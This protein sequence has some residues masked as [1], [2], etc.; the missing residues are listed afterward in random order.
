[1]GPL[2]MVGGALSPNNAAV[3]AKIAQ[4]Q[5]WGIVAVASASPAATAEAYVQ[6]WAA[7]GLYAE[8][9]DALNPS[10][11]IAA[12]N[13]CQGFFFA[14]GDQSR[15]T[16]AWLGNPALAALRQQHARG[17]IL[18]G[19]SAG[20]AIMWPQ[21][22]AGGSSLG[23]WLAQDEPL[24]IKPGLGFWPW[25][26]DQHF[27]ERGRWGRLA[28]ALQLTGL[29]LGVGIDEDT[30]LWVNPNGAWQVLGRGG[31]TVLQTQNEDWVV[32]LLQAG[33]T[34]PPSPLPPTGTE[35]GHGAEPPF[36]PQVLAPYELTR[37]LQALSQ[38]AHLEAL[39][40]AA[41]R[42]QVRLSKTPQTQGLTHYRL[43]L[44]LQSFGEPTS[45]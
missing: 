15:I 2:L 35:G 39:G 42:L 34:W 17:A 33:D 28:K 21:M 30:A 36:S 7:R 23:A 43:Q 11:Q 19:T 1:M 44:W 37:L 38:S 22:I 5:H 25:L 6:D 20:T 31:V 27:S 12:I 45:V 4:V 10:E 14:G 32:H 16:Q 40:W 13:R 9:I 29:P 24:V 18:A 26:T 8:A 41:P 3:Y